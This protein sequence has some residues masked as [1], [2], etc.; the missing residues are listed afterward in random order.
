MSDQEHT[1]RD[2]ILQLYQNGIKPLLVREDDVMYLRDPVVRVRRYRVVAELVK[3]LVR[4]KLQEEME[5]VDHLCAFLVRGQNEDGSW[6]ELHL[7]YD[8]PSALVTALVGEALLS[9]YHLTPR[10]EWEK[11]L[12]K[13]RDYVLSM[14]DTSGYFI[15]SRLYRED[16][17]NVDAACGSFLRVA[18]LLRPRPRRAVGLGAAA[19]QRIVPSLHSRH[20]AAAFNTPPVFAAHTTTTLTPRS[21]LRRVVA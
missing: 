1:A 16:H 4:L 17:L 21:V 6:N 11:P 15:K 13:A 18:V 14:E 20:N 19:R 3:T 8:Q 9:V 5:V 10:N 12:E 7:H 2:M